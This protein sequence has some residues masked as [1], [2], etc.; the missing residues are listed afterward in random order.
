MHQFSW[1]LLVGLALLSLT[2]GHSWRDLRLLGIAALIL[3]VLQLL[4]PIIQRWQVRRSYAEM[5][6]ARDAQVFRLSDAGLQMSAGNTSTTVGWDVVLEARETREFFLFFFAKRRAYYL[7]KRAVGDA[8]EQELVRDLL[9]A[10][11]GQ[12]AATI[13]QRD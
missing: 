3:G 6:T 7:P 4:L 12:R 13:V 10:A 2:T 5:P 9:R 8:V 1:P 11:L